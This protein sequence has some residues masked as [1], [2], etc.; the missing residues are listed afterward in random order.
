MGNVYSL[1][2]PVAVHYSTDQ[3]RAACSRNMRKGTD[4]PEDVTCNPC[5]RTDAYRHAA[6]TYEAPSRTY[7]K[8][9]ATLAE[10]R[11]VAERD[12]LQEIL[13]ILHGEKR[14]DRAG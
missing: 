5:K 1:G 8:M 10:I 3:Q 13:S 7:D 11:E 4:K 12:G 6:G 9:R 2:M 14:R